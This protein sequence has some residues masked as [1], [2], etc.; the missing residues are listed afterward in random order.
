MSTDREVDS[1]IY[2]AIVGSLM[3]AATSTRPDIAYSVVA[4]C[5]YNVKPYTTHLTAAKQVLRYLKATADLGIV[6]PGS[7][8]SEPDTDVLFGYTDSDFAGIEQIESLKAVSSFT[9]TAAR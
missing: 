6:F 4:L 2:Q 8:T 5:R 1:A 9:Y 3:Y 7:S